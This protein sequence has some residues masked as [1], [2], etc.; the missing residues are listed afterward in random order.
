MLYTKITKMLSSFKLFKE[1]NRLC[2]RI[3]SYLPFF[4][5]ACRWQH[6]PGKKSS[7]GTNIKLGPAILFR[8]IFETL[9]PRINRGDVTW[10]LYANNKNIPPQVFEELAANVCHLYKLCSP[11]ACTTNADWLIK[12]SCLQIVNTKDCEYFMI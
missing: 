11:A 4:K 5:P 7:F 8:T 10:F 12:M 6:F 2:D 9:H 1:K 3:S